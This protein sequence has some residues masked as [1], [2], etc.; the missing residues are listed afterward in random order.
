MRERFLKLSAVG[1]LFALT[2]F[3]AACP[4]QK[5]IAELQRD[6]Q[7]YSN[8]EVIVRGTVVES[9]GAMGAGMF[10]IDDGTGRLW[11]YT[12]RYGVPAKGLRVGVVG[13]VTPTF[14]FAGR[15]FATVMR[16][17]QGRKYE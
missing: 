7:R 3:L 8:K 2:L 13:I 6:P 5:S 16:E 1:A 14:S 4:P 15:S 10:E 12:E 17:T 11:V 9:I